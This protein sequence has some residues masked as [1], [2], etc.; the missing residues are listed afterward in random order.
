MNEH[1]PPKLD[2]LLVHTEILVQ[3]RP[4][5]VHLPES[6]HGDQIASLREELTTLRLDE[7]EALQ[8]FVS[9]PDVD[10]N[11]PM[12]MES[13][14]ERFVGRCSSPEDVVHGVCEIEDWDTEVREYAAERDLLVDG[15]TPN[16]PQ[17]L[18]KLSGLYDLGDW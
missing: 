12:L 11:T 3:G 18:D 16:Y 14:H 10:A 13:F 4:F 6:L 1:L 7:D 8:A 2:R 17:L 15:L 9:L 5:T